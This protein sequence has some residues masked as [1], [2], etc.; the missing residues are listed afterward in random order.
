MIHLDFFFQNACQGIPDQ[1]VAFHVI[2]PLMVMTVCDVATGCIVKP[3]RIQICIGVNN[4]DG[5]L[6]MHKIMKF[7]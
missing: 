4:I 1:I 7:N 2:I 5:N 3:T 6:K